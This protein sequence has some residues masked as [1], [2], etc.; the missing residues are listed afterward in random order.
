MRRAALD[1]GMDD[2]ACN[3]AL[4]ASCHGALVDL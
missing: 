1:R 3:S 4:G 2:E